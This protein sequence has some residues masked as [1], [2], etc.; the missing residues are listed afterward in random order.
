MKRGLAARRALRAGIAGAVAAGLLASA[1]GGGGQPAKKRTVLLSTEYDDL[2]VGE[3]AAREI[4]AEMGLYQNESLTEYV[5]EV[6]R[7]LV[8]YAPLRPF[9]YQFKI[10]DQMAPNAFALP[11]GHI[12]VSRGLLAL[13]STEAELA[14]VLGHEI[15][16]AA[17]RHAAAQQELTRRTSPFLMPYIRMARLAAY[18]RD[19]ERAADKGGQ[20]IAAKAGYDPAALGDFLKRLGDT[21]RLTL[22]YSRLPSYFDTHPGTTERVASTAS[23]AVTLEWEPDPTRPTGRSAYLH[24]VAGVVLDVDPAE[25][26]FRDTEFIHPDLDFRIRFPRRWALVNTHQAVGA[27]SPDGN[28]RIFITL[29][30][31][32]A[33]AD[34]AGKDGEKPLP[35]PDLVPQRAEA[36]GGS[37]DPPQ[38]PTAQQAADRF[39]TNQSDE[40][41]VRV[42]REGI[43]QIGEVEAP[44]LDFRGQMGPIA[45]GG[46]VTFIPHNGFVFRLMSVATASAW[47]QYVGRAHTTARTFR[48]LTEEERKSVSVLHLRL[49]RA[50]EGEDIASLSQRTANAWGPGRTAV[51]NGIFVDARFDE[52]QLV[53]IA[54]SLPYRPKPDGDRRALQP[55][56]DELP[57]N[58][59]ARSDS[60]SV[61]A[62]AP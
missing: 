23:R 4:E 12:Y 56:Q 2:A 22:G 30:P 41:N 57:Q 48:S 7:R 27:V 51:L 38:M 24:R 20:E 33:K 6:G 9:Q 16:H 62:E 52:G 60:S 49:V 19:H 31:P 42:E 11:G 45:V 13:A 26:I 55:T 18:S 1:C 50:L 47:T 28:A 34:A 53:K 5:S 15:I 25:G 58:E 44:R 37:D 40:F 36:G 54:R 14:G 8:A 29:E 59:P 32:L 10:V 61:P 17:E 46:Q 35:E 21:E 3:D 39:V 43:V